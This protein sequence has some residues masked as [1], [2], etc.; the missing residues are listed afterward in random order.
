MNSLRIKLSLI[1]SII[2]YDDIIMSMIE[3]VFTEM[4]C[5]VSFDISL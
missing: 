4:V 5:L 3:I 2:R 1:T